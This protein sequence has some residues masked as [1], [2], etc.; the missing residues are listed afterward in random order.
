MWDMNTYSRAI[1]LAA[2][3]GLLAVPAL[4]LAAEFRTGDQ[5][6]H[7]AGITLADDLYMAGGSVSSAGTVRGDLTVVGG[8]VLVSGPVT[9]DV[10][11]AGGTI[12]ILGNVGDDLRAA[13]GTITVQATVAG[14]VLIGGGQITL[15]GA[16]VGG[17]VAIA[18]GAIRVD[19]PVGGDVKLG[20]G[21]VYINSAIAGDVDIKAEKV[22]LGP[23]ANIRGDLTYSAT[24]EATVE[25]GAVVRGATKFEE[26][27]D[28]RG[29][30]KKGLLTFLTL[31][32]L[33]KMI[34]MFVGALIIAYGLKRFARELVAR[35]DAAPW[36]QLL[37]GTLFLIVTPV[38]SILLLFTVIGIPFGIL[39]L[40][41]FVAAMIFAAMLTPIIVGSML[42]KWIWKPATHEIS[43]KTILLGTIVYAFIGL[44]PFIGPLIFCI[45][46]LIAI[47]AA[48]SIKLEEIGKWR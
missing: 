28:V 9:A 24:K 40:L 33:F 44:V 23:K 43:W 31:A 8:N 26:A 3:T 1:T 21:D 15:G 34:A 36:W 48:I 4:L 32:F 20:G 39:G 14:D 17:D 6:S 29:A 38:A 30:A 16:R 47:G 22:T 11:A 2:L 27:K 5:P 41:T 12:T 35:T 46:M 13:G 37:R 18:G 19:T 7:A 25:E 42:H 45:L 10:T